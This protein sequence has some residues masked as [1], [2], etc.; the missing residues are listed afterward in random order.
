M[1]LAK[2]PS[3]RC[4]IPLKFL[5]HSLWL[6]LSSSSSS[7]ILVSLSVVFFQALLSKL[8]FSLL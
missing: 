1:D 2:R 7:R 6:F 8:A 5:G 4:V 3:D